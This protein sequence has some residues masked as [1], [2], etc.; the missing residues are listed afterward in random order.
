MSALF[1]YEE[2]ELMPRVYECGPGGSLCAILKKV[3]GKAGRR[4]EHVDVV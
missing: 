3:N 4:S 1:K 2:E